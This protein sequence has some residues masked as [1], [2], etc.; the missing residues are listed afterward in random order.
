VISRSS[1]FAFG[2]QHKNVKE[3]G[4]LLGV[5]HVLEGSVQKHQEKVRITAQLIDTTT[6]FHEFSEAYD[7]EYQDVLRSRR[8]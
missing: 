7:K 2:R 8:R 4:R 3:A 1:S 5:A 6:G